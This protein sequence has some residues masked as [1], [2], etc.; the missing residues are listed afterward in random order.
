M[1][2]NLEK[3]YTDFY[4]KGDPLQTYP[5]EYVIR[6][7]LGTYPALSLDKGYKNKKILDLGMGDGRNLRFFAEKG[8]KAFG[9]EI[10]DE[11]CNHVKT[12]L[13]KIGLNAQIKTGKN[14]SIPFNDSYFDY[15]LSWNSSYYMGELPDYFNYSVYVKEFARVLKS[16]AK[17]VLS[18]PV[19]TNFIYRNACEVK[20]SYKL[21]SEDPYKIR[22]G[23]VFKCFKDKTELL[24]E[25]EDYFENFSIAELN[26]NC[27]GQVN[28]YIIMVCDKK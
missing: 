18:V 19:D 10:R 12:A 16:G 28:N 9:V 13:K 27:F 25:F 7:F 15:L 3:Q 14:N 23:H 11:I 20:S 24:E 8:F 5:N 22:N 17:L 26:D 2:N 1:M 4:L 21:I 6:V